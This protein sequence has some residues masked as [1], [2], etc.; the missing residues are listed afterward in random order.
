MSLA[1][2]MKSL[3]ED[4]QGS[5]RERH[6]F[7]KG[8][9][10]DVKDLLNRFDKEQEEVQED[11]KKMTAE[12]RKFLAQSEKA[13]KGDFEV[14]MKDITDRIDAISKMQKDTRKDARELVKV[15]AGEREK[16]HEYW[17]SLAR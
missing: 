11:L 13:R 8:I 1:A 3:V 9:G 2:S 12:V 5:T 16:A 6:G 10:K 14:V 7:V 15:Y 17:L 4:I